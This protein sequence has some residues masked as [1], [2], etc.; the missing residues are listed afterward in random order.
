MI[1]LFSFYQGINVGNGFFFLIFSYRK[2]EK[3]IKQN[4]QKL[5]KFNLGNFL[6]SKFLCQKMANFHQEKKTLSVGAGSLAKAHHH[7]HHSK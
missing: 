1:G 2:F 3:K 6:F 7:Y 5:V 4:N